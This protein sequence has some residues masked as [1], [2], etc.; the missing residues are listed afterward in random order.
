MPMR[1]V[2]GEGSPGVIIPLS[3]SSRTSWSYGVN[4]TFVTGLGAL[5]NYRGE[6]LRIERYNR[7]GLNWKSAPGNFRG[8]R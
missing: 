8:F 3:Q 1:P 7:V 6:S 2:G 5:Y 4:P